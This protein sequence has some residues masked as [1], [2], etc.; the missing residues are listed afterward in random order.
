MVKGWLVALDRH[1][2]ISP[3]FKENELRGLRVG[4]EG[5]GQDDFIH[6]I[7]RAQNQASGGDLIGF[8]GSEDA[9]QKPARGVDGIDDFHLGMTHLLAIDDDDAVLRGT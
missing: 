1:E 4:M 9:A 6:Q 8:G 5:V 2:V 3:A 7:L